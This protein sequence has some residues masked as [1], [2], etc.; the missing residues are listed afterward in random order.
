M[1]DSQ[2]Y[3]QEILNHYR[4]PQNFGKLKHADLKTEKINELCGDEIVL[5]LK[6]SKGKIKNVKFT[7]TGCALSVASASLFTESLKGKTLTQAKNITA[8]QVIKNLGIQVG[9]ARRK[10][11]LLVYDALQEILKKRTGKRRA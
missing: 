9:P 5:Q 11:V 8:S 10:C 2:L 7:G 1:N 4:N 3:R 6:L